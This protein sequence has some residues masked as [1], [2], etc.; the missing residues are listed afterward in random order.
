MSILKSGKKTRR[1]R[2]LEERQEKVVQ[3]VEGL[4]KRMLQQLVQQH[5]QLMSA[6]FQNH[7]KLTPQEVFDALG[8]DGGEVVTFAQ[9][10]AALVN[11]T[12]GETTIDM[13]G[14]PG[15][16]VNPDGTVTVATE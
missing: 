10:L 13:S 1:E 5:K 11:T 2:T 4:G 3:R 7:S 15:L 16:T 9:G 8:E 6:M 12:T 14:L